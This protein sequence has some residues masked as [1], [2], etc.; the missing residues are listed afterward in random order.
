MQCSFFHLLLYLFF[1]HEL[2]SDVLPHA[3]EMRLLSHIFLKKSFP[4]VPRSDLLQVYKST[5]QDADFTKHLLETAVRV[6]ATL[7]MMTKKK[8]S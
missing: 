7:D 2:L 1:F 6:N 8:V 5:S 3:L 4:E